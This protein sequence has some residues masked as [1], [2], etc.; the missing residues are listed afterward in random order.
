LNEEDVVVDR[1]SARNSGMAKQNYLRL[2]QGLLNQG[3]NDSAVAALDKGIEFFPNEKFPFDYQMLSWIAFYYEAGAPEKANEVVNILTDNY[4]EDLSYYG[5]LQPR[6]AAYYD[7]DVQNAMAV[8]Q[9]LMQ[10]TKQ[11]K[12]TDLSAEIEK[13][14]YDNMSLL[15]LQ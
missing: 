3:K 9:R 5:S 14:F 1:E 15:Q 4:V 6:F 12:Q 8:L 2:A 13:K 11:Y 7:D 10:V